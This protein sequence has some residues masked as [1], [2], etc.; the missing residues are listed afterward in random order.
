MVAYC[1]GELTGLVNTTAKQIVNHFIDR[2]ALW[3]AP[4]S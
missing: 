2:A 1:C 3:A 4:I